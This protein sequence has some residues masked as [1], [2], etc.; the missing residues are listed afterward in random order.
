LTP[1]VSVIIPTYQR[2]ELVV[3][4]A[5][6]VLAQTYQDFE[7]I[8]IDDGSTDG[9][10]EAVAALGD[11]VR[12]RWQPNRGVAAARNAGVQISRAPII[13]FLDSDNRWLR[14]HL[15]VVAD[16][17]DRHPQ[18]VLV[19][20]CPDKEFVSRWR[21][22]EPCL[23]NPFPDNLVR[24]IP[25]FVSC[26]AVRRGALLAAG[27]FDE[28]LPVGED[29]AVWQRLGLL[30]DFSVVRRRTAIREYSATSLMER[31]AG[32]Y[33]TAYEHSWKR[34]IAELKRS[35]RPDAAALARRADGGLAF[36]LALVA[37]GSGDEGA[38]RVHMRRAC[39]ELPELSQVPDAVIRRMRNTLPASARRRERLH[40]LRTLAELWPDQRADTAV[41]IT[42]RAFWTAVRAGDAVQAARLAQRWLSGAS[43]GYVTRT[44]GARIRGARSQLDMWL[45][46]HRR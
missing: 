22:P 18:A 11:R 20:T 45:H 35:T 42:G 26:V 23:V 34:L 46:T 19:T 6:S 38:A 33:A 9:T 1:G 39:S 15:A 40:H 24:N 41:F 14:C 21:R 10:D 37:I 2:R 12:Y 3:R 27:G 25:G 13:A 30:G 28:A 8:V 5:E 44:M 16:A 7:L 32:E 36:H 29:T 43:P 31:A 4:A 17:L